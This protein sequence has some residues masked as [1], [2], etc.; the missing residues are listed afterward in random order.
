MSRAEVIE[1]ELARHG[2]YEGSNRCLCGERPAVMEAHVAAALDAALATQEGDQTCAGC[3]CRLEHDGDYGAAGHPGVCP[4]HSCRLAAQEGE[5]GEA[6]REAQAKA[7]D[8]CVCAVAGVAPDAIHN[9]Y[10]DGAA[11]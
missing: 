11:R 1:A 9:P 7:W 4:P 10:R 8:E 6:V 3:Q 2:W 5:Q